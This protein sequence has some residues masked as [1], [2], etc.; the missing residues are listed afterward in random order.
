M[1]RTVGFRYSVRHD[2]PNAID[3]LL[4]G[5]VRARWYLAGRTWATMERLRE[6]GAAAHG[7]RRWMFR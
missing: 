5:W 1:R 3:V 6:A 7:G 2:H 4:L